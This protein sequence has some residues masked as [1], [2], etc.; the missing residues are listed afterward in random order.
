MGNIPRGAEF[1]VAF[2]KLVLPKS[3][4]TKKNS[5]PRGIFRL[6]ENSLNAFGTAQGCRKKISVMDSQFF[7]TY[8]YLHSHSS[9]SFI[10]KH[11]F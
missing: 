1:F 3:S 2:F 5:A 11:K 9:Y 6:V 8:E 7:I 4:H 10:T